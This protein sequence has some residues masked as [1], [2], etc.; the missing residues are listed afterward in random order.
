[1]IDKLY[2]IKKILES[3]EDTDRKILSILE[4]SKE[5]LYKETIHR[6]E[7]RVAKRKKIMIGVNLST[8]K[9]KILAETEDISCTGAFIKTQKK[10]A[11]GKDISIKL[12]D[13]SGKEFTF[14]AKVM[15]VNHHG[16]GVMVKAIS[17]QDRNNLTKFL[18]RL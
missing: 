17:Q 7:E 11:P 3:D 18:D 16:I 14:I 2:L 1:M 13:P 15:R 5:N 10:I 6:I 9:E 4:L 12:T 8:D